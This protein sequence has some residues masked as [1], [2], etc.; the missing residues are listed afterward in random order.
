MN[1]RGTAVTRLAIA[2]CTE[3]GI[4]SIT[5]HTLGDLRSI[6]D[7]YLHSDQALADNAIRKLEKGTNF[8]NAFPN[9]PECSAGKTK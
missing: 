8:P 9:G 7:A 4:A 6:L 2:G 3:P 5:G 1:L